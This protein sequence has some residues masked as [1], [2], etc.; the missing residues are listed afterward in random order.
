M[1]WGP[2]GLPVRL[3]GPHVARAAD[4]PVDVAA[5]PA[6][7]RGP[8]LYPDAFGAAHGLPLDVS[9][10]WLADLA[11]RRLAAGDPVDEHEPFYLRRPDA[12]PSVPTRRC[13]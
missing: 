8:G 9:A 1:P 2:T 3:D 13:H 11:A 12:V 4:L 6:V 10:G 5:L 7:G